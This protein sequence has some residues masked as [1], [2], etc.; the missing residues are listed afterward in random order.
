M[1]VRGHPAHDPGV[2][3]TGACTHAEGSPL[4]LIVG[5]TWLE[6][7]QFRLVATGGGL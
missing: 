7:V 5:D 1:G 4:G 6:G 2:F 3:Q